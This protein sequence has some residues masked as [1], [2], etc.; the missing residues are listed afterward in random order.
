LKI[1]LF[2]LFL[3]III[4]FIGFSGC[5]DLNG[6]KPGP[7]VREYFEDEYRSGNESTLIVS[8]VNG[9][10]SITSWDG[11]NI[12][13]NATKKSRYG[14]D[15]LKKADIIVTEENNDITIKIQHVQPIKS[16]SVDL[17]IKIPYNVTLK[18]A[19][20]INGPVQITNTKGDTVLSN[21]NGPIIAEGIDGYVKAST[22]NGGV[23]LKSTT[24]VD[25][26]TTTNGRISAEIFHI[27]NNIDIES[28]N[29]GIT[30]YINPIINASIEIT[31]TNGDISIYDSFIS[32]D[33]SSNKYLRGNIGNSG[34]KINIVT[35]NGNIKV[36]KLET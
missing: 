28:T 17:D 13:L 19:T 16:R 34:Y 6:E 36:N 24:G 5:I 9:A 31:T 25:D 2:T 3:I 29:G 15:D 35:K 12:T 27:R 32:V 33:E 23:D 18:S 1:K 20:S 30:V 7:E 21:T 10:I 8:T 26:L 14:Y 4:T 22:T 11:I